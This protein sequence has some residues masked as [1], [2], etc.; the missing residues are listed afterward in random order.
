MSD[1]VKRIT[2]ALGMS[3]DY[4]IDTVEGEE[5]EAGAVLL[6]G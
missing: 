5:D 1:L 4:L 3:V 6:V 2:R